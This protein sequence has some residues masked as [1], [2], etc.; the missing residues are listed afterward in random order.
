LIEDRIRSVRSQL[1]EELAAA[2]SQWPAAATA[3]VAVPA[4]DSAVSAETQQ[5]TELLQRIDKND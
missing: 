3:A 5:L 2:S 4:K 1:L